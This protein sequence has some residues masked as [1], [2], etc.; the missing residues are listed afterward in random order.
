MIR[1][2]KS[3][4]LSAVMEIWLKTNISAHS[5]ISAEYWKN[6]YEYV[7]EQIPAAEVYIYEDD[8]TNQIIGFIGLVDAF[9]VG[10]F[11]AEK[12]RSK[13]IGTELIGYVKSKRESLSLK[14]F[15]KNNRAV[16][17]YEKAGFT[18]QQ[19]SVDENTNEAEYI[20]SWH[21]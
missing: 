10:L 15:E 17:F 12:Y 2:Y 7:S 16:S 9:V 8:T 20:M 4:D 3:D 13:G 19:T 6:N 18:V 1:P 21:R 5:F 11:V 14:V